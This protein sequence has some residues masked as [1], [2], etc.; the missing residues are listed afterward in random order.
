MYKHIYIYVYYIHIDLYT[1][2]YIYIYIHFRACSTLSIHSCPGA[3]AVPPLKRCD[4]RVSCTVN[5]QNFK[6]VFAA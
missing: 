2:I 1:Y 4:G 5:F 3:S 6:L